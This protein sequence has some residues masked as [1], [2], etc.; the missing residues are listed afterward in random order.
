MMN[1]RALSLCLPCLLILGCS[2]DITYREGAST[3]QVSRDRYACATEALRLAPVN[4]V[5]T[6]E[7]GMYV[8]PQQFCDAAGN[9]TTRPGYYERPEII[10]TDVNA[11]E[12][13]SL[14]NQ[15]VAA[16]GYDRVSL[17]LCSDAVKAQVTP[18]ITRTQPPLTKGSCII[19]RGGD[20]YQIVN[21][22]KG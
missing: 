5:T 15:C 2:Q 7:P 3:Q 14:E 18:A 1:A 10:T 19:P 8:P 9:C 17:P 21:T 12:R 22:V 6:V 11:P 4:K 20:N 16:K 13:R